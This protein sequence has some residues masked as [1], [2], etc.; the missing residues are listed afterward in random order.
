MTTEPAQYDDYAED[1]AERTATSIYN[2]L[3]DRPNILTLAGEVAGLRVL[4]VGCAAGHLTRELVDRGARVVGID[5]SEKL[6]TLARARL[7]KLAEFHVADIGQPLSFLASESFDLVVASLVMHYLEEWAPTL[8]EMH[9]VLRPGGR[10]VMSTHHPAMDWLSHGQPNYFEIRLLH[11]DWPVGG[12]GRTMRVEF[13]R[14]PLSAIFGAVREAGFVVDELAEPR[15]SQAVRER[16]PA[17]YAEMNG[18]P[19]F[20][21]LAARRPADE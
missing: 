20:L 13:Y 15:P 7:G 2:A 14:R 17:A 11:E 6:I 12:A 9:R 3:Y 4:D 19:T 16:D 8:S 18:N 1:Y 10:F 21:Y 5:G